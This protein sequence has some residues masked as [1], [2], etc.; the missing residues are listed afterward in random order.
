MVVQATRHSF[1][2]IRRIV[3]GLESSMRAAVIVSLGVLAVA[4]PL[5]MPAHARDDGP[6][7]ILIVA[8][9]LG[10]ADV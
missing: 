1:V 2:R 10:L 8:D 4:V 3:K 7:I 9:D 5:C 6:N